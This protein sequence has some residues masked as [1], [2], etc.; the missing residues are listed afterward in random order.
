ML[1]SA[2]RAVTLK[3]A[4]Q[5]EAANPSE[6]VLLR[7]AEPF[8]LAAAMAVADP[9]ADLAHPLQGPFKAL[10]FDWRGAAAGG[11]GAEGGG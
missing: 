8:D 6:P 10:T 2:S 5:L 1:I 11:G 3:L 4:N 7:G 9:S